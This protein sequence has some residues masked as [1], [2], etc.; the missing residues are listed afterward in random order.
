MKNMNKIK[1]SKFKFYNKFY[2][3][4]NWIFK[5]INIKFLNWLLNY[6]N[7]NKKKLINNW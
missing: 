1:A 5:L 7:Y 3:F 2:E 4:K 6:Q